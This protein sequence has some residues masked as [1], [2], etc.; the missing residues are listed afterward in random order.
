MCGPQSTETDLLVIFYSIKSSRS[1][2]VYK[3]EHNMDSSFL[4][5]L[6]SSKRK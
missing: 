1:S 4:A 2:C 6:L 3:L 5:G